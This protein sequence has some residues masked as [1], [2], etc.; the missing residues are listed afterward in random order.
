MKC[1]KE[2]EI[3]NFIE[4]HDGICIVLNCVL[5]CYCS[6]TENVY[7]WKRQYYID[8][9]NQAVQRNLTFRVTIIKALPFS[10]TK[11]TVGKSTRKHESRVK[12]KKKIVHRRHSMKFRLGKSI[13]LIWNI[14]MDRFNW[15]CVAFI[16][17]KCVTINRFNC[18]CVC[19]NSIA[20]D[21]YC[22]MITQI[23]KKKLCW[24]RPKE[25]SNF[26]VKQH[27][28]RNFR[29]EY[30]SMWNCARF[31]QLDISCHSSELSY[32]EISV[33]VIPINKKN[34]FP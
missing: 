30:S 24:F 29:A 22:C 10:I 8:Y 33:F 9:L 28:I 1:C 12:S 17:I 15:K 5:S 13:K 6:K 20:V 23:S 2:F 3:K 11:T 27:K 32:S 7:K 34:K 25:L 14:W 26:A 31:F 21:S 18:V 16:W 19:K 4:W